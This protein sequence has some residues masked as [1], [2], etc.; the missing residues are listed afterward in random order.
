MAETSTMETDLTKKVRV[1]LIEDNPADARLVEIFLKESTMLDSEIVTAKE[2]N[3]GLQFLEEEEFDVILLD[4]T[5]PDSQGFNTI[6]TMIQEFPEYT[7]I[8]MTGMDDENHRPEFCLKQV[9]K[10]LLLKVSSTPTSSPELSVTP[11]NVT[12]SPRGWKLQLRRFRKMSNVCWMHK[13]WPES[14]TGS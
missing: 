9:H 5:L 4:L 2:L 13:K 7:I 14:E 8:V 6:K 10:T 11:L 3:E 12:S 1:L